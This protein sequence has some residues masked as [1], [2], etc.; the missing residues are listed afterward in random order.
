MSKRIFINNLNTYVSQ[1]IFQELRNDINEEGERLKEATP[2]VAVRVLG[3]NGVPEAG[4]EFTIVENEKTAR[5]IAEERALAEKAAEAEARQH[6]RDAIHG[7][8]QSSG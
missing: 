5:D 6:D 7:G 4:Q 8:S 1:A 3:L 2:S